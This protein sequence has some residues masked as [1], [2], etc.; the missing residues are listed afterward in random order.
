[1]RAERVAR[2]AL[3]LASAASCAEEQPAEEGHLL[4]VIDT[5]A[6]LPS[7]VGEGP[8]PVFDTVK[9]EIVD[10]DGNAAC[11]ACVREMPITREDIAHGATFTVVRATADAPVLVHA[12]LFRSAFGDAALN[13]AIVVERWLRLPVA[14]A[15]GERTV[16]LT[17]PTDRVGNP[18][19][20]RDEPTEPDPEGAFLD[21]LAAQPAT[22]RPRPGE[23]C[24]PGGYF[25]LGDPRVLP[26]DTPADATPK[27]VALKSFCV[28]V[29]EATV[30]E[31][32]ASGKGDGAAAW[33]GSSSP[34][35]PASF[36]AYT[37]APGAHE[38][39]PVACIFWD[40]AREICQKRGGDLPTV[41]Q[42]EYLA[43]NFGRSTFLWGDE[44]PSC[45]EA[46]AGRAV[47][48]LQGDGTCTT[49]PTRAFLPFSAEALASTRD[50]LD[51]DGASV[52]GLASNL[53][54]WTRD[55]VTSPTAACRGTGSGILHD[56]ECPFDASDSVVIHG[57]A[58]S[59]PLAETA[60]SI[61]AGVHR[62]ATRLDVGFRCVRSNLP[63]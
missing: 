17:L 53:A 18:M 9:I 20:S 6:P 12:R 55:G 3:L 50:V 59:M 8:P 36:C 60:A 27:L 10:G 47:G 7:S 1:M 56:P 5:D 24:V 32:R 45:E 51:V 30:A 38:D 40:T 49:D 48:V 11:E 14:P 2:F 54:E 42:L 52:F 63:R 37:P 15:E 58:S 44:P 43:S 41:A 62:T 4:V 25:W 29:H 33:S 13:P 61:R 21:V 57:G 34:E 19:G 39:L 22:A 16:R 35:V 28:D 31:V 23:V 26:A 46:V